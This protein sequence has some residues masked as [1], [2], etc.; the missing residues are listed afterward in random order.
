MRQL[1]RLTNA[2]QPA[3]LPAEESTYGFSVLK[4]V[5]Y[6]ALL[7]FG[8]LEDLANSYYFGIALFALVPSLSELTLQCLSLVYAVL[9]SVFFYV[10]ESALLQ[11]ALGLECT[12][13]ALRRL[14][15]TYAEEL[16]VLTAINHA[17]GSM[18]MLACD[19]A[20]YAELL[21][22]AQLATQDMRARSQV[23]LA[24]Q[25]SVWKKALK[26]V[27]F[28]FGALSTVAGSYFLLTAF[29]AMLA[30]ALL[31][32][33]LGTALIVIGLLIGLAFHYA[34]GNSSMVRVANLD[35]P[36]FMALKSNWAEFNSEFATELTPLQ[37][38]FARSATQDIATQTGARFFT[39]RHESGEEIQDDLSDYYE[40]HLT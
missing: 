25:E 18:A 13:T 1:L 28:A 30:P 24:I 3:V 19:R 29:M 21:T 31:G 36:A 2:Q 40:N 32:T 10:Y 34:M 39:P 7:V 37:T 26:V 20:L 23:L 16:K 33:A 8:I 14:I 35:Y 38:R 27:V 5:A 6:Y 4:Q 15:D 17:L 22:C 11:K 12:P 9:D